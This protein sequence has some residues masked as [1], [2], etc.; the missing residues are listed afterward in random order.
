MQGDSS[1]LFT[2]SQGTGGHAQKNSRC[3]WLLNLE[4]SNIGSDLFYSVMFPSSSAS[5]FSISSSSSLL[6]ACCLEDCDSQGKYFGVKLCSFMF[7]LPML[8]PHLHCEFLL[9]LFLTV[10]GQDS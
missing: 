10:D 8:R 9:L 7:T 4:A 1:R 3:P 6:V 2:M 5:F